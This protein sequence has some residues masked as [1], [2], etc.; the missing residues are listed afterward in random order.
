MPRPDV[1][2]ERKPQIL[3]AAMDVFSKKGF[4][5]ARMEDIAHEAQLSIGGLYWYYKS[6]EDLIVAIMEEVIDQ[7]VK[8][9]RELL[10]AEGTVQH[11]LEQYIR[12]TDNETT[13]ALLPILYELYSLAMRDPKVRKYI[14][15][16]FIT[17]REALAEFVEQGIA[18]GEFRKVNAQMAAT[19]L[20]ALY[21]GVLEMA[22]FDLDNVDLV[23]SVIEAWNLLL[24]GLAA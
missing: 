10:H 5:E 22:M 16:F 15:S 9:L 14:R 11:R 6:K 8:D 2:A 7:D 20:V 19:T 3:K 1:S 21:E 24:Q 13:K 17:Y 18:R 12:T 23:T 4:H